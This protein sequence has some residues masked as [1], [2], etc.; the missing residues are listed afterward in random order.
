MI[1]IKQGNGVTIFEI[2]KDPWDYIVLNGL[3]QGQ[4]RSRRENYS[5][6]TR[7]DD[8][9]T[10]GDANGEE[11][12]GLVYLPMTRCCDCWNGECGMRKSKEWA[13]EI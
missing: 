13:P 5:E 9:M 8:S 3:E 4:V 7:N 10:C 1:G 2:Y 11:G 12:L 6:A